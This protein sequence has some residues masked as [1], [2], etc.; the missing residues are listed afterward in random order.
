[1][2]LPS[3]EVAPV[4]KTSFTSRGISFK[5]TAAVKVFPWTTRTLR[6][7]CLLTKSVPPP[8]KLSFCSKFLL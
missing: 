3:L 5:I 7:G 1:M 8:F 2:A 4:K 6:F